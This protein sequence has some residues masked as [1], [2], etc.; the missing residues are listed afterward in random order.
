[1]VKGPMGHVVNL[2]AERPTDW[3]AH[4]EK[5][6]SIHVVRDGTLVSLKYN[7]LESPMHEP[8][9]QE[10]RGMVVC[11]DRNLILAH[12][13]NKFWNHGEPQAAEI[14][15]S[16]ANVYEKLDGSLITMYHDRTWRVASSGHPT[17]GGSFGSEEI[18]FRD[19]FWE[20]WLDLAMKNPNMKLPGISWHGYSFMFEF[21]AQPNRVVVNHPEPRIVLHGVRHVRSGKELD[22]DELTA[23]CTHL[24]WE[25]VKRYP[26]STIDGALAAAEALDPLQTEG[27]VVVDAKFNRVKIKSPRY[28]ILHHMK[29]AATP[30]RAIELW[31]TGEA[32]ELLSHFP[33]MAPA[34]LPIHA[35]LDILA[36]RAV[37]DFHAHQ[38]LPDRKAFAM[39]IKDKPWAPVCFKLYGM[40]VAYAGELK[41]TLAD[42]Q[43]IMRNLGLTCLEK[44]LERTA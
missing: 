27:F 41:A 2:I 28:V 42:A 3:L 31:V 12:P 14:D 22:Y 21:C 36:L 5:Q 29:G 19:A 44:M 43:A 30:R 40:R 1:M 9:V 16:T 35:S 26:I 24:G 15:W 4:L 17:A 8:I 6:Y 39:A 38:S 10:C 32:S 20:T 34:I 13:Y 37:Q 11:T 23:T 18:T 7:Q 33:E 25:C